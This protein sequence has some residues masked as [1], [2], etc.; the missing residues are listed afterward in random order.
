MRHVPHNARSRFIALALSMTGTL[1]DGST[2]AQIG[3][4]A[5]PAVTSADDGG[6]STADTTAWKCTQCPF[7]TG[8][9]GEAALGGETA[10]GANA[11]YGQYTGIDHSGGY[12]DADVDAHWRDADGSYA[13][14]Q[15]QRLGLPARDASIDGGQE[16]R[17]DLRVRYDGQPD[18]QYSQYDA[19]LTP[20][21]GGNG[22]LRLPSAWVPGTTT[23]GMSALGASLAPVDIGTE[24]RTVSLLGR[25]LA[26]PEWTLFSQFQRQEK[27]GTGVTS[28]SFLTD[29]VQ[30]PRYVDYVTDSIEAGA[31]WSGHA[32]A[33]RL[34]YTGSWFEDDSNAL[35]FAN[36]YTP[37]VAGSTQGRLGTPPSNNLQQLAA[38]GNTLV[39]WRSTVLTYAA[40]LSSLRQNAAFLPVS[41][42]PG[43][44]APTAGALDG[45]VLL[46]HYALGLSSRPLSRLSLRGN[47]SFDGRDD[48]TSPIP[49]AYTVTDT[50][51]G[52]TAIAPRYGQNKL[53]LDGG[54]DYSLLRWARVGI[55]GDYTNVRYASG[56]FP[57]GTNEARSWGRATVLPLPSMSITLKY[58]DAL[59]KAS[60]YDPAALPYGESALVRPFDTA[61]RDRR[62]TTLTGS[63]SPIPTLAWTLEAYLANDDYRSSPLGLQSVHERRTSSML[64]WTPRETLSAYLDAGYQSRYALQNGSNGSPNDTW[65]LTD[66]QRFW[67]VGAGGRWLPQERWTAVLDYR[68]APSFAA[69][70]STIGGLA[71]AFPQN[72]TRLSS[73]DFNL[74]YRCSAA[75][76]VRLHLAH[77]SFSSSDWALAG[78]APASVPDLLSLG[79]QAYRDN[80][81][82][83]GMTLH[84]AFGKTS[85]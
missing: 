42:L 66:T 3:A 57:T 2:W 10:H 8:V 73:L 38:S 50:Y 19:A 21:Q 55:G 28:A 18:R 83:I 64:S 63:W 31:A 26:T 23:A 53:R 16:G 25:Y 49:V 43:A 69:N 62:F 36:P 61:P 41:T 78:V 30:L 71:Q 84:Y 59:R 45:N 48:R 72:T 74:S 79:L 81:N 5:A 82:L 35:L 56:Q 65:L 29:A 46:S 11:K 14:V 1:A 4:T 37:L 60:G 24:R 77:E 20:F 70:D 15:A 7:F 22:T 34:T 27:D 12:V 44:A 54:A 9:D 32:A 68:L 80:V 33:L 6:T 58:G 52:G 40:S 17:F 75:M 76:Q 13:N 39:P 67:N 47:A 85:P 51:P